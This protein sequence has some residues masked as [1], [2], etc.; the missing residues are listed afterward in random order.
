MREV[1]PEGRG[2]LDLW[3]EI[4]LLGLLGAPLASELGDRVVPFSFV[5]GGKDGKRSLANP[6]K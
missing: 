6:V 3:E 4:P 2:I 5:T 1:P